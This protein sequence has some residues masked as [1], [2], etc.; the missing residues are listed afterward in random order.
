[1]I[2]GLE[3]AQDQRGKG[4]ATKLIMGVATDMATRNV[5]TLYSHVKKNNR[6]SL[7]VHEK[8]GFVS[9]LDY[10]VFLDGSVDTRSLSLQKNL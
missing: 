3:T 9:V 4:F 1:M 2:A 5:K 7:R 8:C 6:R 10:A